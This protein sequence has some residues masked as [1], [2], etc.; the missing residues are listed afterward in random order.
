MLA[1]DRALVYTT[2]LKLL[3]IMMEK[4]LVVREEH[5]RSHVYEA[6]H[7]EEETQHRLLDDLMDRAFGG[8]AAKLVMRVLGTK[9]ASAAELDEIR[10]LLANSSRKEKDDA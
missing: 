4:G 7:G 8:S 10:G 6:S 2:T 3:Q 1:A 9:W 5:G